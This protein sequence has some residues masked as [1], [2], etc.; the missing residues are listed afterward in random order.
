[1]KTVALPLLAALAVATASAQTPAPASPSTL[2]YVAV[3]TDQTEYG[4]SGGRIK[5]PAPGKPLFGQDAQHTG[6]QPSYRDHGD[7]TVSDLNTG[8]MWVQGRGE[9]MTWEKAMAGT[10][11]CRVGHYDDWRVPTIKELYSLTG[12]MWQKGDSGKGMDWELAL[13][14]AD[15][16]TLAGH[17]DWRL[18]NAKELQ[19]LVDYSRSPTATGPG[20]RGP[21]IAPVFSTSR[22]EDDDW[23]F[24]WSS[25]TH[26]DGP[27][28]RAGNAA[29]YVAFGRATGWM[30]FPP[31]RG[32]HRLL[33]VHGAGAQRS[34]PKAGDPA[35]FPYGRGPQG[36]T[37]RIDNFVRC[38][39]GGEQIPR[40]LPAN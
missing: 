4:V 30:Q 34:D 1:M 22:L 39:R 29:V 20:R 23:P 12:S 33:D 36:D 17:H 14:Y 38:V 18:P 35:V 6:P 3:A 5:P 13:A 21:A 10:K 16:L 2:P 40:A 24:F 31:G 8:L 7:G 32:E 28:D 11:S 15:H 9:R 26:L 37:I 25:T 19:S 27:P